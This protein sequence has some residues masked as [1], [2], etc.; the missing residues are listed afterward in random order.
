M[1]RLAGI[2]VPG[3]DR[4]ITVLGLTMM[5]VATKQTREEISVLRC[6]IKPTGCQVGYISDSE[7]FAKPVHKLLGGVLRQNTRWTT[8]LANTATRPLSSVMSPPGTAQTAQ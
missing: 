7:N 2:H 4:E 3:T 1:R 5:P 8:P 6:R